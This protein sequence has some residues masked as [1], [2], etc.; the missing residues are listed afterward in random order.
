MT[1]ALASRPGVDLVSERRYPSSDLLK[2]LLE[3]W[4]DSEL[5][6]ASAG[7]VANERTAKLGQY[8]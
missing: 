4:S 2:G 3:E 6:S 5:L 7:C 8:S 1:T